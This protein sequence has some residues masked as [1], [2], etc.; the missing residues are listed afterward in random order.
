MVTLTDR[1]I[2]T[3]KKK[4]TKEKAYQKELL[5]KECRDELKKE[6]VRRW[7]YRN[8]YQKLLQSGIIK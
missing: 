1:Q 4:R 3:L 7:L 8:I 2:R 5:D 6:Y